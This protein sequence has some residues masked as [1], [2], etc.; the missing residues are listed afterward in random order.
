M[1]LLIVIMERSDNDIDQQQE[2]KEEE[3]TNI[4]TTHHPA[5]CILIYLIWFLVQVSPTTNQQERTI[6]IDT[7]PCNQTWNMEDSPYTLK[8][9]ATQ[10]INRISLSLFFPPFYQRK[11]IFF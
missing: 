1:I 9:F 5:F 7:S 2:E 4:I 6:R 10:D 11:S 3:E 8:D